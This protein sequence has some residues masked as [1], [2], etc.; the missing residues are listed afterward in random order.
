MLLSRN[1]KIELEN[2]SIEVSNLIDAMQ[3]DQTVLPQQM[4]ACELQRWVT[5]QGK[6]FT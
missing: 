6:L 3:Y 5:K 2:K 1:S 4:K